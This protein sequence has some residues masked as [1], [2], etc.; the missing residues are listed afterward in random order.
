MKRTICLLVTL[1]ACSII[2]HAQRIKIYS[3]FQL[4]ES[5]KYDEAKTIIEEVIGN[6]KTLNWP[7]IWYAKGLLCQT[8]YQEGIK[9]ND[10]KKYELYPDQ[11]YL[12]Y[13]SYEKALS[14]DKSGRYETQLTPFYVLL[15]ND[16][17]EMGQKH[18]AG[19]KY[20]DA[21]RA[22]EH[23]LSVM[24]KPFLPVKTDTNLV[25][26]AGLAAYESQKW[27]KAI[28]YLSPLHEDGYSA[29]S[30]HLL[31]SANLETGDTVSAEKVLKKAISNFKDNEDMVL[32][33]T[34]LLFC[35]GHV[36][37]A[38]SLLNDASSGD[39]TRYIYP[40]TKGLIYQKTE[41]Y[42]EA[43]AAY[44]KALELASNNH[45]ILTNIGICYN[46]IGVEIDENARTITNNRT[47]LEEKA[48]STAAFES[49]VKWLEKAYAKDQ[50]NQL[51]IRKLHELYKM[52][53]LTDKAKNIEGKVR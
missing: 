18:F 50:D 40:Y 5:G 11:L 2:L 9:K 49:A 45:E 15:A 53:N 33:L 16:F 47:F 24:G 17:Q 13:E 26:N 37:R 28:E 23:A 52:L 34:D 7:R 12:A 48:K 38:I 3:V 8:A 21:L 44:E 27:Q 20:S 19:K 29:N 1:A 41:K 6:K 39:S 43:I 22:F 46:N 4:I 31:Y 30:S 25:Y 10:K 32:L 42:K 51:V 35:Q 14:L 36:E